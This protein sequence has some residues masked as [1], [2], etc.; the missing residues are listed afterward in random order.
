MVIYA[1]SDIHNE[2][3][4]FNFPTLEN[5]AEITLVLAGDI[6]VVKSPASGIAF[7]KAVS[8]RFKQIVIILGNHEYY[9]GSLLRT[10]AKAKAIF[11]KFPNVHFLHRKSVILDGV[12]FVG[13]TLWTDFH[14]GDPLAKL[15]ARDG[16]NDYKRIRTGS[17]PVGDA[18]YSRRINGNDIWVENLRDREFIAAETAEAAALGQKCVVV[19]HHAPHTMSGREYFKTNSV[20]ALDYAYYNTGLEDMIL[21]NAPALWIHGHTHYKADY[22]IGDTRVVCNPRGYCERDSNGYQNSGLVFDPAFVLEL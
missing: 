19:S 11:D 6:F 18:A 12:R 5:E 7:L 9:H 1:A 14:N 4:V 22:M 13:A 20:S 3:S 8:A 16:L 21:D 10:P 15:V 2:F 17:S